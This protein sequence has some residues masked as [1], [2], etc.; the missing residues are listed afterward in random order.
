MQSDAITE[1]NPSV[2]QN[3]QSRKLPKLERHLETDVC[4]VGAGISG[5]S[6]AYQLLKRGV[7]VVVIDRQDLNHNETGHTSAH[8]T[9]ALDDGFQRLKGLFGAD[10][11]KLAYESHGRAIDE[12][13]KICREE[14]IECDF[15]RVDGYLFLG[16]K[17]EKGYLE[18]E[19]KVIREAGGTDV[20][21]VNDTP[22][23]GLG[24]ALKFPHQAQ[25]HP[26]KY[27]N[28]LTAA[29]LRR[30]GQIYSHTSA[31]H[32]EDAPTPHVTTENQC[33]ISA[34]NIVMATNVPVNNVV[35]SHVRL[36]AYRSYVIGIEVP[37]KSIP[38]MLLWDT[39]DP[40]HYVRLYHQPGRDVDLLIV[41]GA[42]HRTGQDEHPEKHFD[43]LK[44]WAKKV[45]HVDGYVASRWSGQIIEPADSLALIGRNPGS[46]HVF[47]DAGDSGH[48]LTHGTIAGMLLADLITGVENPWEKLYN[49]SR[50]T[51]NWRAQSSFL[52][53]NLNTARQYLDWLTPGDVEFE[54][55]VDTGEGAIVRD[56]LKKIAVYRDEDGQLHRFSAECPHMKGVVHWNSAEKSWDCPCHG[57]RFD[58]FGKVING[59][60]MEDLKAATGAPLT[61]APEKIQ[62]E[63]YQPNVDWSPNALT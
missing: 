32:I 63:N 23:F 14:N 41:G 49:P 47:I 46:E 21:L 25:F 18:Q 52:S 17:T 24:T 56:G 45:L 31:Q 7:K 8:L 10:G 60:A 34:E 27:I 1:T 42:D 59:P 54:E 44:Q 30:G 12:I 13:E 62:D 51:L 43:E 48:G 16:P 15:K 5:L 39:A 19:L 9:N 50:L 11:V 57:S 29:I 36:A 53:E 35:I 38:A 6:T 37:A 2:W 58:K 33:V 26:A 55:D 28:G 4:I 22:A 61:A 3:T 40:Y 20:T